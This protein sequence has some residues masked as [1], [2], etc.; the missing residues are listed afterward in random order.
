MYR[1]EAWYNPETDEESMYD[2]TFATI[3]EAAKDAASDA[4]WYSV[5]EPGIVHI[6]DTTTGREEASFYWQD[7]AYLYA[8]ELG[9]VY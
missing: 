4:L 9:V 2:A 5:P 6:F 3:E 7:D 8:T 1:V